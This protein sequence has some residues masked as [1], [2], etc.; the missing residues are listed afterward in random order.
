MGRIETKGMVPGT[1][2]APVTPP[3]PK[4]APTPANPK[5]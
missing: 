4:P 1:G 2:K 3:P 5:K